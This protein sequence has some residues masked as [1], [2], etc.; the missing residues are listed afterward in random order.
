M[1]TTTLALLLA[2][3]APVAFAQAQTEP[4][5][6]PVLTPVPPANAKDVES[7]DAIMAAPPAHFEQFNSYWKTLSNPFFMTLRRARKAV[8]Q[9]AGR[10]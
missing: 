5:A 2:L 8:L 4:P 9:A 10:D 1:R 3:S 6:Q 7:I